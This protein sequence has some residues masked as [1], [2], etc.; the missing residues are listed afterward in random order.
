M[1]KIT[2][3]ILVIGGVAILSAFTTNKVNDQFELNEIENT[4]YDMI[5]WIVED[6][7]NGHVDSTYADTYIDN[8]YEIIERVDKL[9]AVDC[10][11][12]DEI[13]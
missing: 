7:A 10:E 5:E 3:N 12:C 1:K 4:A 6:V 13:D 8:L 2:R 9:Q 11:N